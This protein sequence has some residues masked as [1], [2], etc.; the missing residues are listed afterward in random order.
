M[1]HVVSCARRSTGGGGSRSVCGESSGADVAGVVVGTGG[2]A[3]AIVVAAVA[4]VHCGVAEFTEL[5]GCSGRVVSAGIF[6][7]CGRKRTTG[8]DGV[9]Y[10]GTATVVGGRSGR[11]RQVPP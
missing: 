8:I 10:E 5:G 2:G 11:C 1:A 6:V 9:F 4:A 7:Q 3:V